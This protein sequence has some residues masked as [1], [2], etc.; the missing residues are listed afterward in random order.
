ML[1]ILYGENEFSKSQA[2]AKLKEEFRSKHGDMSVKT[3][4]ANAVDARTF[5]NVL[6]TS[7]MFS[8]TELLI[9]KNAEENL[10]LIDAVLNSKIL[11]SKTVVLTISKLDKR[12]KQY[13]DLVK[14]KDFSEFNNLSELELTRWL[15]SFAKKMN[16]KLSSAVVQELAKRSL[17]SQ[18]QA[19]SA[20]VQLS[21]LDQEELKFSDPKV[22]DS[23]VPPLSTETAFSLLEYALLGKTQLLQNNLRALK[24][25]REDAH[26]IIGLICSQVFTLKLLAMATSSSASE[27]KLHPYVVKQNLSL[28]QKAGLSSKPKLKKL[29]NSIYWLDLGAKSIKGAQAW[30]LLDISLL[31]A[32]KT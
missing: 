14:L 27:L 31:K 6:E 30:E 22:L 19:F 26:Q 3:F 11:D 9:I 18:Q 7:D 29:V 4:W 2:T 5:P 15:S 16:L 1:Q 32:S 20:L 24:L 17:G 23:F 12:S 10:D 13:K 25:A 8:P 28:I 21:L